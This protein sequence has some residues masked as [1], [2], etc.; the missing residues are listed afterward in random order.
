MSDDIM[1]TLKGILGD[2]AEEK[3]QSVLSSLNSSQGSADALETFKA[4]SDNLPQNPSTP[5]LQ[6]L[7]ALQYIGKLQGIV[8]EMGRA[9][10]ARSTLLM[11]LKPYM[12]DKRQKSIDNAIKLL[13]IS[14]ISGLFKI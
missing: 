7:E 3:I 8:S 5:S 13:N 9:N 12:R 4:D 1:S 6:N 11:S 14:K 2:D 10:D